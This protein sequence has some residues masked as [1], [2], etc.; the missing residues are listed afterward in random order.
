MKD[1]L[2]PLSIIL[3]AICFTLKI[4]VAQEVVVGEDLDGRKSIRAVKFDEDVNIDG[5]LDETI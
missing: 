1:K 3:F 4:S 2:L 5:V